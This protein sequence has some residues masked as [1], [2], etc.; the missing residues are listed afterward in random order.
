MTTI[1]DIAEPPESPVLTEGFPYSKILQ[2]TLAIRGLQ[3]EE[4]IQKYLFPSLSHLHDPFV[5]Q[6]INVA[7]KR[8]LQAVDRKEMILVHG[9]YDVDG[10]TAT[11]LLARM[12]EK[13]SARFMTFLPNRKA[14]GYGVRK[15][16]IQ[17]AKEKDVSLFITVDCGISAFEEIKAARALGIDVIII[18]HHRIH[19]GEVPDALAIINPIQ[20]NCPYSFKELS[21]CGLAFKLAQAVLGPGAFE[22]LD[23]V[24]LSTICDVSPLKGE[25]R[26]LVTFGLETLSK[27]NQLGFRYLCEAA[28]IRRTKLL[29]S[30][31]AFMLGPRIN[32]CGRMSSPDTALNL[33]TTRKA[34]EAEKLASILNAENKA[35][36]QEEKALLREALAMVEREINFSREKVIVVSG[37]GWHEG[38]IGIVAQRLVEQFRRPAFV[39]AFNGDTGK[40]S[41]RSVKGFHLFQGLEHCHEVLVEF[42]GHELAAGFSMQKKHLADFKKKINEYACQTSPEVFCRSVRIDAEISLQELTP[43][44]LQEL[45]LMEPFGVGNP[46][47]VFLTR[48]LRTKRAPIQERQ[49]GRSDFKSVRWWVTDGALSFEVSYRARNS[50]LI[51]P[52][53]EEYSLVYSPKPDFRDGI[54]SFVLEARD[55]KEEN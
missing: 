22:F 20:E 33:L 35:R 19:G 9:D 41:G 34:E 21:A 42:G 54:G 1:W 37:E 11:A 14:N 4:V 46:R 32:A 27:R 31:L 6:G 39:V 40:G 15:E 3:T 47:P 49:A 24:A 50:D 5:M 16:A 43:Q 10:I 12:F 2:R 28:G 36:Q 26:T 17:A 25:N 13:L 52:E 44:F 45:S 23:L 51:L 48:H 29:A 7:V 8:V 30:D 55:I 53:T 38:V 18:D